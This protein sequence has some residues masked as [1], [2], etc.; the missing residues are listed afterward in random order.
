M[1]ATLGS[2]PSTES[3]LSMASGIQRNLP[4]RP[5]SITGACSRFPVKSSVPRPCLRMERESRTS[6]PVMVRPR[7]QRARPRRT[8]STSGSSG[9]GSVDSA[10]GGSGSGRSLVQGSQGTPGVGGSFLLGFLLRMASAATIR[11]PTNVQD[12]LERTRMIR[13]R[14]FHGIVDC[15]EL[16]A[17]GQFLD[18]RLPIGTG[19]KGAGVLQERAHKAHHQLACRFDVV[20]EVRRANERF[21]RVREDR[22][23][24]LAV[25]E[26]LALPE[27]DELAHAELAANASEGTRTHDG[28][29][30]LCELTFRQ[31]G[32]LAVERIGHGEPQDGVAEEL[33]TF[34]GGNPTVLICV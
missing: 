26:L 11:S 1:S 5:T 7:T 4:R 14:A 34:V 10:S 20:G 25:S 15:S 6:T 22:G 29:S 21:H 30:P 17:G 2:V 23:L 24:V 32:V 19:S 8:T 12:G 3:R 16:A 28:G 9:I 18:A 31:R 27:V 33:K 13:A